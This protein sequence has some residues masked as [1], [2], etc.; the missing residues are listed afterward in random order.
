MAVLITGAAGFIGSN[1]VHHWFSHTNE[2]IINLDALTYA[3][4]ADNLVSLPAGTPHQLVRG[5]INDR[6]LI[7][8]LLIEH[9][10]RAIMHFAAESHVDRSIRGP[11]AF[12]ETN[13]TG[14]FTI[15][16]EARLYWQSLTGAA[17]DTFRFLHVST[18][19]VYGSLEA[20]DPAFNERNQYA[21]NSPYA[22]S[23]AASDH[24]VRA[25][26]HTYGM[27]TVIT[28]GSLRG[29][30]GGAGARSAR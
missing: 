8:R 24:F 28:N 9:Q 3:G 12:V 16:D 27:P 6:A 18:D 26:H 11:Q 7:T 19:E 14:T 30:A 20:N 25:Y 10:P 17:K 2:A 29:A 15:L 1:F 22:A 23:K 21:P 5:S 4:N 13:V